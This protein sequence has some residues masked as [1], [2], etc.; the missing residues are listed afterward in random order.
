[1]LEQIRIKNWRTLSKQIN[2][3]SKKTVLDPDFGK[4]TVKILL[5]IEAKDTD[6]HKTF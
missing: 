1:M 5:W 6:L 2:F 3:Q 4:K